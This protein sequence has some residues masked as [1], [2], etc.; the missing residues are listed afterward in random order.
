M[1]RDFISNP[2]ALKHEDAIAEFEDFFVIAGKEHDGSAVHDEVPYLPGD[3]CAGS[4]VD[5]L[6]RFI[7]D[8][9]PRLKSQSPSERNLLLVAAAELADDYVG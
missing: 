3:H 7:Q 6:R 8:Q 5:A 2:A 1:S 4:D 9:Y